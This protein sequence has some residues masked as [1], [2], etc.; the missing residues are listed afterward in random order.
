MHIQYRICNLQENLERKVPLWTRSIITLCSDDYPASSG[1]CFNETSFSLRKREEKFF[2]SLNHPSKLIQ[3]SFYTLS[4]PYTLK[5]L[6][7]DHVRL[8]SLEFSSS[9]VALFLAWSFILKNLFLVCSFITS[10]SFIIILKIIHYF[11]F[12]YQDSH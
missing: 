8:L 5:Y 6:I 3:L 12:L 10:W 11:L 1:Q 2:N 7:K 4:E 9:M